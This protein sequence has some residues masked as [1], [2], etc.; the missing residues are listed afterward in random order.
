MKEGIILPVIQITSVAFRKVAIFRKRLLPYLPLHCACE[1]PGIQTGPGRKILKAAP[2]RRASNPADGRA[3][4]ES[5]FNRPRT[6][7]ARP[8]LGGTKDGPADS[9][10]LPISK[11]RVGGYS[12]PCGQRPFLSAAWKARCQGPRTRLGFIA[13][14]SGP[15]VRSIRALPF[16]RGMGR[17]S[18]P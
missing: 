16:R 15:P 10:Q 1:R 12:R 4:S 17:R 5:S 7:A 3:G 9:F 18:N 6:C 14:C 13:L 8:G 11:G 2:E